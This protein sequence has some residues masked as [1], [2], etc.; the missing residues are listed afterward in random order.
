FEVNGRSR[1]ELPMEGEH[2]A[3]N[4]LC[5]IGVARRLGLDDDA[6]AA[7]LLA[8]RPAQMRWERREIAFG[9]GSITLIN[10]AYNANPDSMIASI[11]TFEATCPGRRR[12]FVMGDMFELGEASEQGHRDVGRAL[13]LSHGIGLMIAVGPS[14]AIAG[15]A[16][17]EALPGA[18]VI[19][20]PELD[21]AAIEPVVAMIE[22]G[23]AVLL[24]GSRRARLERLGEA[25]IARGGGG[26]SAG[27]APAAEVIV[28][29][30]ARA[31][32][33]RVPGPAA[34]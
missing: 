2:N 24:K 8:V 18:R 14:A 16:Y 31:G 28:P 29:E 10:D 33:D 20:V 15:E 26:V 6:I 13:A 34:H 27:G 7:G 17:R 9:S 1:F 4:A 12:V 21:R 3:C 30:T 23:D 22:P 25:L 5:A 32:V 11:R 19:S